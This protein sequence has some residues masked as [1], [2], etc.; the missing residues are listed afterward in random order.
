[1]LPNDTSEG[2]NPSGLCMCGCGR[3]TPIS[4]ESNAK[5]HRVRGQ[6]IRFIKGHK[7]PTEFCYTVVAETGCWEWQGPMHPKGYGTFAHELAHR[8]SY[9]MFVGDIPDGL[10]IDHLCRNKRCVN[11][12][13]LEPVTHAENNRRGLGAKLTADDASRIR[14][15]RRVVPYG[16]IAAM[17][18]VS[19][20]CISKVMSGQRWSHDD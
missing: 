15:L 2:P 18:G 20:G 3:R 16:E 10:H 6:P 14:A 11:P 17:Y 5:R 13:H 12:A 9:E 8:R 19:Y 7:R 4:K 1:M